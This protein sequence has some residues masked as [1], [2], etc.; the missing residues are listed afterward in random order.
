MGAD[1]FR[2]LV[3]HERT[4]HVP[5][6][7]DLVLRR[8]PHQYQRVQLAIERALLVDAAG[9]ALAVKDRTKKSLALRIRQEADLTAMKIGKRT[10]LD[11]MLNGTGDF[12]SCKKR[13]QRAVCVRKPAAGIAAETRA[14]RHHLRKDGRCNCH[15]RNLLPAQGSHVKSA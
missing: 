9:A 4:G 2:Y 12:L 15:G 13:P 10:S 1:G 6:K 7:D 8:A 5:A 3:S 11:A 14:A